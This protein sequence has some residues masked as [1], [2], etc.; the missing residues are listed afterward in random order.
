MNDTA[1]RSALLNMQ[2]KQA[3]TKEPWIVDDGGVL[4]E[5]QIRQLSENIGSRHEW[6]SIGINDEDGFAEVAALAHPSNAS[7]IVSAINATTGIADP[8]LAITKAREA[9]ER[10]IVWH[11]GDHYQNLGPVERKAW[12]EQ[13][14]LLD[15]AIKLLGKQ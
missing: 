9:L 12:R 14:A 1:D 10:A 3:W 5:E 11:R 8:H 2:W 15:E 4:L 6:A 13:M 7:R